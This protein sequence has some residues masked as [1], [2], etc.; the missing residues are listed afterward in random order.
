M[1]ICV[2]QM[3]YRED[4]IQRHVE[5]IKNIIRGYKSRDLI[6]FPELIL[7]G[8]PSY[9]RPEGFLYRKMKV[10]YKSVSQD[11]YRY[12]KDVGARVIIGESKRWGERY[13]NVA[14]YVDE[15]T[16]QSYTKTHV[17][18]TENFV[19]GRKLT[20]LESPLGKIGI[21]ICFD[22]A[23]SEV[24]RVLALKGAELIV[25]ISAVPKTFPVEYM[26]RRMAGAAIFNQVFVV[27]ANR[28]GEF[29]SGHSAIFDPRGD[30]VINA[31]SEEAVIETDVHME[32]VHQWR[33]DEAIYSNRRPLL[34]RAIGFHQH[35]NLELNRTPAQ[36][37]EIG[38]A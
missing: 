17:H 31:G 28:P 22:A 4:N 19:P 7:H 27:Y 37:M 35:E 15:E 24:W 3:N 20:V 13:Y 29:F 9:E 33:R 38:V 34:Y 1:K 23:F 10:I 21:T 12:I 5:Q 36:K 25:N 11:I 30:V 16:T 8:H 14:T 2:V 18:W 6:V 32:D 26:W